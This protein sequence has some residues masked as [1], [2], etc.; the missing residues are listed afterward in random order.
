MIDTRNAHTI[1]FVPPTGAAYII[2]DFTDWKQ[3]P[4]PITDPLTL[5]FPGGAYIEYAFLDASKK[6]LADPNNPRTPEY[7]WHIYDRY[8]TLPDNT[9]VRPPRSQ[10]LHGKLTTHTICSQ[11]YGSQRTYFVYEPP[12]FPQQRSTY[13]MALAT[14]MD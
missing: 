5:E 14:V 1:T 9:F 8:V 3:A 6:P 7:P 2:G 13:R 11:I 12:S 4:M 10:P